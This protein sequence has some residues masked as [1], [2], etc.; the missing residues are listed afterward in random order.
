MA[1]LPLFLEAQL[2][3]VNAIVKLKTY[4]SSKGLQLVLLQFLYILVDTM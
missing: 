4:R 2:L 1:S 3:N